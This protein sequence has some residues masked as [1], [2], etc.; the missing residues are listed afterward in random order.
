M[1]R[2]IYD[3]IDIMVAEGLGLSSVRWSSLV[4][5]ALSVQQCRTPL[6]R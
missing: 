4:G 2:I 1:N 5:A 6:E 3:Q